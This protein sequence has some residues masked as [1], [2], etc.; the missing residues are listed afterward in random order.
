MNHR[1]LKV[2]FGNPLWIGYPNYSLCDV[3]TLGKS[4]LRKMEFLSLYFDIFEF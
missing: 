3:I 4:F 2:Q 1:G